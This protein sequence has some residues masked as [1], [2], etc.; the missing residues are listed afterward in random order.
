MRLCFHLIVFFALRCPITGAYRLLVGVR[1]FQNGSFGGHNADYAL[2]PPPPV[3]CPHSEP[4]PIPASQRDPLRPVRRCGPGFCGVTA[5]PWIPVHVKL[6]L[7]LQEWGLYFPSP[8]DLLHTSPADFQSQVL[9]SLLLL[10]P[11]Q[12]WGAWNGAQNS[13]FSGRTSEI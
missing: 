6:V 4:Q 8:I 1:S 13:C 2:R 11:T 9:L 10:M 12:G 7:T 5:L 3:F